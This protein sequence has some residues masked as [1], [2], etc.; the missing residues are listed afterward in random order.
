[1]NAK[2]SSKSDLDSRLDSLLDQHL[3]NVS[4]SSKSRW[5]SEVW[6]FDNPSHGSR[7]KASEL[8]WRIPLEDN[9]LLTDK[10]H[11]NLL[12][13]LR[14]V[15]WGLVFS[16]GDG[17]SALSPGSIGS[18]SSSLRKVVPWLVRNSI[19]W[20]S[21]ITQDVLDHFLEDLIEASPEDA[22]VDS[23]W[24]TIMVFYYIWRQRKNLERAGIPPMPM[25]PWPNLRSAK[26]VAEAVPHSMRGEIAPLPDEV[27]VPLLNRASWFLGTPAQDILLLR[28]ACNTAY[29]RK[30]TPY[31]GRPGTS[32]SARGNQ[33]RQAALSFEFRTPPG[34]CDPWHANLASY[35]ND[36]GPSRIMNRVRSLTMDLQAACCLVLQ[37]FTGMRASELCGLRIGLNPK[38]GLPVDV[39]LRKSPSGLNEE[40]VIS[41]D[42]SKGQKHPTSACWLLGS[43]R[44]G[45]KELPTPVL[46]LIVLNELMAPYRDLF[47]SGRL[48]VTMHPRMGLPR[49][50]KSITRMTTA[51]LTQLYRGFISEWVNLSTLPNESHRSLFYNDLVEWRE[52][53]GTLIT[54]HQLRKTYAHYVLAIH[55][56]LLP[57]V[58]RQFHHINMAVTENHYWGGNSPQIEP[59]HSVSRQLTARLIFDA[60]Q[61]R[62][63]IAGKMGKQMQ[64][65]IEELKKKVANLDTQ[66]AW[67]RISKWV[68]DEDL[69]ANHSQHGTC[70]PI[71]H[72]RMECWKQSDRDAPGTLEPNY[73]GREPSVCA[74]CSCFVMHE[75]SIP[76]WKARYVDYKKSLA[77]A[78]EAGNYGPNFR[79]IERRTRMAKNLLSHVGVELSSLNSEASATMDDHETSK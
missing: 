50:S 12:D 68:A 21:E 75:S 78:R 29:D 20:P 11:S 73:S 35:K 15:V 65:E 37:G 63:K 47:S 43:R 77:A 46:A 62:T 55:S 40:F 16:P 38:T 31:K 13:W 2:T 8:I 66:Q 39:E 54:T 44:V 17:A 49:T 58:K 32:K 34:D 76:F 64:S 52:S 53:N 19:R 79:E 28:D 24:L 26:S 59:I 4:I 30:R 18:L 22:G 70:I 61:G 36:S 69:H 56:D 48:L 6:H 27:A 23:A 45:D 74:G 57:A 1:M 51:N 14:R 5:H 10:K 25:K 33:Q 67:I 7:S 9:S 71:S 60:T 72:G 3:T 41:G 42:L